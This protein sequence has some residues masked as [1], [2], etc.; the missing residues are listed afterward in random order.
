MESKSMKQYKKAGD[1]SLRKN[2]LYIGSKLKRENCS[3]LAAFLLLT[4]SGL[5]DLMEFH[6]IKKFGKLR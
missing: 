3:L 1:P 6:D 2:P 4:A 5:L